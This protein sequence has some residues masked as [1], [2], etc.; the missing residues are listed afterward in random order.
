M[1]EST[2]HAG[3]TRP[4][5]F[6]WLAIIAGVAG[7]AWLIIHSLL[8]GTESHA[9]HDPPPWWGLGILPFIAVLGCIAILPLLPATHHWWESNLHRLGVSITFASLTVLYY[10][11]VPY[12]EQDV[13]T[14][15]EHAIVVEYIPFIVLLFALYVISGGISLKG[16]L[17]ARPST[18]T[19]FLAV[20]A[21]IASFIGTTGAS[22]LLIRPLIQ[23]NSQRRHV[24]H[25]TR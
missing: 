20:G 2:T 5:V 13:I 18:N 4:G 7:L 8:H 22:M 14:V 15:L 19:A 24:R 25:S 11:I 17:A 16:D 9:L 23:T 1:D 10:L 12:E 21:G 3:P 6:G